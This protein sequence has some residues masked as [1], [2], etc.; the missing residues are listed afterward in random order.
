MKSKLKSQNGS[1][2]ILAMIVMVLASIIMLILSKQILNQ[3]KTTKNTQ[4]S[5]QTDYN[6]QGNIEEGLGDF[7]S[8][9]IIEDNN[10]ESS[11]DSDGNLKYEATQSIIYRVARDIKANLLEIQVINKQVYMPDEKDG[12]VKSEGSKLDSTMGTYP[13]IGNIMYDLYFNEIYTVKDIE[14]T[15]NGYEIKT[16]KKS[17]IDCV[18]NQGEYINEMDENSQLNVLD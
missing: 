11:S 17:P 7:I 1:A 8:K 4:E 2:M 10:K 12:K 15:S 5:I 13:E 18:T 9:V 14:K 3:I 16:A 6:A